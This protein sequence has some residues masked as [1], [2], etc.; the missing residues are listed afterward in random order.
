MIIVKKK[1]KILI[2][3]AI[4]KNDGHLFKFNFK[5]KS[6][7][8]RCFMPE[9]PHLNN[10]D[11][12]GILPTVAGILG[13]L[14]ANEVIKTILDNKIDLAGNMLFFKGQEFFL[15]KIK[16]NINPECKNKC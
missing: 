1:K 8:L 5:K 9:I 6:P 2:S 13:T 11:E 10:C 16:I 12:E 4:S 7:C 3:A 15:K 14:Q